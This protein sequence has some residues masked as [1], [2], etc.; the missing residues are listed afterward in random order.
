M[1]KAEKMHR[2]T[3]DEKQDKENSKSSEL[4]WPPTETVNGEKRANITRY[5]TD[6][7]GYGIPSRNVV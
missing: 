2:H 3:H 1:G 5:K 4:Q 7:N 6:G